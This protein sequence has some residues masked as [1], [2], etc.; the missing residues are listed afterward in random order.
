M[1]CNPVAETGQQECQLDYTIFSHHYS[2]NGVQPT[3]T[4]TN[5]DHENCFRSINPTAIQINWKI[6]KFRSFSNPGSWEFMHKI[7]QVTKWMF[8][9]PMPQISGFYVD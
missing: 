3:G 9:F 6:R 8:L 7:A 2:P 1:V 4:Q 5:K